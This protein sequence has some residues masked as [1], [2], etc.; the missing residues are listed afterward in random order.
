LV[1]NGT[2]IISNLKTQIYSTEG[3][4]LNTQHIDFNKQTSID[5]SNL[6]GGIY[7]LKIAD[8]SGR[9]EVKKF[10]KQ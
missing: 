2:K 4:I 9:V 5:V 7:F 1:L 6:S 3:K 10:V 8:E